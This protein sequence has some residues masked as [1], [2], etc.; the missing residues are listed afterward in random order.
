AHVAF[1]RLN[2]KDLGQVSLQWNS[3]FE[4]ILLCKQKGDSRRKH[5]FSEHWCRLKGNI[6]VL[7]RTTDRKSSEIE[8]VV[9]LERF[10]ISQT[11]EVDVPHAFRLEFD[12]GDPP[13]VFVARSEAEAEAW[14]RHLRTSQLSPTLQRIT[15]LRDA[16]R[17]ITGCDPLDA[18]APSVPELKQLLVEDEGN[19]VYPLCCGRLSS[20]S[21][22]NLVFRISDPEPP[23]L[24]G[25]ELSL[26]CS[27]LSGVRSQPNEDPNVHIVV[28]VCTPPDAGWKRVGT[29]E[30]VESSSNPTF[31]KTIYLRSDLIQEKTRMQFALFDLRDIKSNLGINFGVIITMANELFTTEVVE[32][33]V[34]DPLTGKAFES[35]AGAANATLRVRASRHKLSGI[36]GS[37]MDAGLSCLNMIC[38]N[39][40]SKHYSFQHANGDRMHVVE[41]MG[42]S[43]L[44]FDFPIEYLKSLIHR[45]HHMYD[46]L[47][48]TGSVS[49]SHSMIAFRICSSFS[50]YPFLGTRFKPCWE[51]TNARYDFVP[52]NLHVNQMAL[53][54]ADGQP[55]SFHNITSVGVFSAGSRSYKAGGL[56]R[57]ATDLT[58][59]RIAYPPS[60]LSASELGFESP[61]AAAAACLIDVCPVG[62]AH[63]LLYRGTGT[64]AVLRGDLSG[65]VQRLSAR[66]QA[67]PLTHRLQKTLTPIL[68]MFSDPLL[69]KL[70]MTVAIQSD[71][72]NLLNW[73]TELSALDKLESAPPPVPSRQQ[74]SLDQT[75]VCGSPVT[76]DRAALL[77]HIGNAGKCLSSSLDKM[78]DT[79]AELLWNYIF[80]GLT[81]LIQPYASAESGLAT[82]VLISEADRVCA[83]NAGVSVDNCLSALAV[84]YEAFAYRHHACVCQALTSLLTALLSEIPHWNRTRWEQVA[85]CGVLAQ[86]E[87]LL[88][89]YGNEQ[90]MIEDWAWA[91]EHLAHIRII[92]R[93]CST[94]N[95]HQPKS[96]GGNPS[97]CSVG[98]TPLARMT[99][100]HECELTL[101][102]SV[103]TGAPAE[104][105]SRGR[106]RLRVHP[107]AFNVG[108]N[109]QQTIAEKQ[110]L[111]CF[112][113]SLDLRILDKL[114]RL[115]NRVP[116]FG[117]TGCLA[118]PFI[119]SVCQSALAFRQNVS[120]CVPLWSQERLGMHKFYCLSHLLSNKYVFEKLA[121]FVK[122]RVLHFSFSL[123]IAVSYVLFAF[124]N[125][126]DKAA[127]QHAVNSQGLVRLEIYFERFTKH[128]GAPPQSSTCQD[129][130]DL[131][132]DVR[133]IVQSP[134]NKPVELLEYASE[135]TQAFG[136]LRLTSCKSAKD[137]T[138][139]SVTL[140][141]IRWLKNAEGLH[142][143]NF[144]SA[145]QCLRRKGLRMDNVFKNTH[146]QK[147]AFNRFQLL[148]FPRA[149][150]PPI[151]TYALGVPS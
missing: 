9:L 34:C 92:L 115:F 33:R 58:R 97:S 101:P 54:D 53:T 86:F 128:Y 73:L 22:H 40:M 45:E 99:A 118:L 127:V 18:G 26:S 116:V 144:Q 7:C 24:D 6:L 131:I 75:T 36:A 71:F 16:L 138:S 135:I 72:K 21:V 49:P 47:S 125:R 4:G 142:E 65:L 143:S 83:A 10:S 14:C 103:W 77:I 66:D 94:R 80:E 11:G 39:L 51:R 25:V 59:N 96:T 104:I 122:G 100:M 98:S 119:D 85:V 106:V 87:G 61:V 90:G 70:D 123:V 149:Y 114:N 32:L 105:Q 35:A 146:C 137:R 12:A 112:V 69:N 43:R 117:V 102:W 38:D 19:G 140:E 151:G 141:Q 48:R 28:S 60:P 76:L 42:E 31:L 64:L 147:Y 150:R 15:V 57:I 120:R 20:R 46:S 84:I 145:L 68:S 79:C 88:S 44:C 148:Y 129:I 63:T 139:M 67:E 130:C 17:S 126:F 132:A 62:R 134:R 113:Y 81:S 109:E 30:V 29:T 23:S 55:V 93:P 107:V 13:L 78:W 37:E 1:S 89:C 111:Y 82:N 136:G 52:T 108:I 27:N 95:D 50:M 5:V 91:I 3:T 121:F 2:V 41:L 74:T 124:G 8:G 110:V 133:H 56:F